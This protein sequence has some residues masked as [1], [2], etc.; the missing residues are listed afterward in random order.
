M[1]SFVSMDSIES[2]WKVTWERSKHG[3]PF[4]T[5][6]DDPNV[7]VSLY[8]LNEPDRSTYFLHP[9][10]VHQIVGRDNS[11]TLISMTSHFVDEEEFLEYKRLCEAAREEWV[12]IQFRAQSKKERSKL[13]LGR[14][15]PKVHSLLNKFTVYMVPFDLR[16]LY[17]LVEQFEYPKA[18]PGCVHHRISWP[19]REYVEDMGGNPKK[20]KQ[21]KLVPHKKGRKSK[22]QKVTSFFRSTQS[23]LGALLPLEDTNQEN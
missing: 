12:N 5:R 14:F 4:P 16:K 8:L 11:E 23:G 20:L 7:K 6:P 15:L 19:L 18:R 22:Q 21:Q 2:T 9:Y 3:G 1:S 10:R 13:L 17:Q